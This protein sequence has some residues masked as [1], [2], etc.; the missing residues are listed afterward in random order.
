MAAWLIHAE[1]IAHRVEV[2]ELDL[3]AGVEHFSD[4]HLVGTVELVYCLRGRLRVGPVGDDVELAVGDSAWF[5]A[6]TPHRYVALRAARAL[7][8]I[9]TP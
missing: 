4:G 9:G 6:D 2:I 5:R 8:V 3:P 1:S 7:N